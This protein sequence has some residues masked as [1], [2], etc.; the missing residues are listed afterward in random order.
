MQAG[1]NAET[2]RA[3]IL[4]SNEYFADTGGTNAG[5][6]TALYHTFLN[7]DPDSTG[8][9]AWMS[10]LNSTPTSRLQAA[11]GFAN[12]IENRTDVITGFYQ[13]F[14]QRDPDANG[15]AAWLEQLAAGMT[16]PQIITAFVTS[17]EYLAL[18]GVS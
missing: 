7:R 17:P 18:H 9:A 5:F 12:S 4:G 3:G 13:T 6:V 16:Q 15:L 10:M 14:L 8:F 2:I 1:A 11:S